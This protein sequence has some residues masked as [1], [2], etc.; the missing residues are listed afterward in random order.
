MRHTKNRKQTNKRKKN[1]AYINMHILH[2]IFTQ[3]NYSNERKRIIQNERYN[4][5]KR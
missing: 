5:Q 1:N 4:E 3:N 2:H